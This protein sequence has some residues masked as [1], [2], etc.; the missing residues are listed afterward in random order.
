MKIAFLCTSLEAG[1]DGVGDYTR[2]LAAAC[3]DA[4]QTCRLFAIN[5]R[6][7]G[8]AT[9]SDSW[10]LRL[11]SHSPWSERSVLLSR[12][13]H[14]FAPDWVSWQIVPYG[15]HPKGV[16]PASPAWL[17]ALTGAWRTHVM[18]HELWLGLPA[19]SSW[20]ERLIGFC[21]RRRLL[22]FLRRLRPVRLH[23][24]N[25]TYQR[26]LAQNGWAAE[27]L[28]LFGNI[29]IAPL[30]RD[31]ALAELPAGLPAAPRWIGAMF[32]TLHAEWSAVDTFAWLRA[33]ATHAGRDIGIV[34]LGHGGVQQ[35]AILGPVR[36]LFPEIPIVTVGAVDAARVSRLLQA[37][38]FGISSHP[39]ALVE[40]SGST[41]ALLEHGL[42][43][44]VPRDEWRLRGE[45][46]P[47]GAVDPLLRRLRDFPP[48]DLPTWLAARRAPAGRLDGVARKFLTDLGEPTRSA[49]L[50]GSA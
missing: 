46:A 1:R 3:R 33:A 36:R 24:S 47:V 9:A 45:P 22:M 8:I 14:E 41:V 20:R 23:T 27:V 4:G 10:S 28:P 35:E 12:A 17:A 38:D 43:V 15:F 25:L 18:L 40:K 6:H 26:V 32:G 39:W 21:Q 48:E 42:P 11:S 19:G 34:T 31:L 44:L 16:M 30:S 5:D 50:V 13:L 2:H 37:A 7:L 29:P 49:A